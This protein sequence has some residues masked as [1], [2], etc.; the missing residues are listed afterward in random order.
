MTHPSLTWRDF[1]W[2]PRSHRRNQP[3]PAVLDSRLSA[4]I[5]SHSLSPT[6]QN[7]FYI[8]Q[9]FNLP[10]NQPAQPSSLQPTHTTSSVFSTISFIRVYSVKGP[11]DFFPIFQPTKIPSSLVILV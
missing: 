9:I 1:T 4:F 10:T 2:S 11:A 8:S 6:Q 7:F 5:P 3:F